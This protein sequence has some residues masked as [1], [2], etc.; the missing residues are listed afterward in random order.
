MRVGKILVLQAGR[1]GE[2]TQRN[3]GRGGNQRSKQH[4]DGGNG[5]ENTGLRTIEN[6]QRCPQREKHECKFARASNNG[7]GTQR[8]AART[9]GA[10]QE[11]DN[12]SLEAGDRKSRKH[13]QGKVRT[14]EIDIDAHADT[15]EEQCE[16]EAAE[17][18]DVGLELMPI[19][20]F[21]KHYPG[22][23]CSQRHRH[24]DRPH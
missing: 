24:S 21:G 7:S 17:G 18:L 10:E 9:R 19:I 23:E 20:G 16:E 13:D 3:I 8:V 2:A 6:A 5:S 14:H 15:H 11:P 1:P 4:G 12:R 22:K